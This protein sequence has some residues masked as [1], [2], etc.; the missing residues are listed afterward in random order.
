MYTAY[1]EAQV[2]FDVFF[3]D[4]K[5][6]KESYEKLKKVLN[7]GQYLADILSRQYNFDYSNCEINFYIDD[8]F[9][10]IYEKPSVGVKT[11]IT[12]KIVGNDEFEYNLEDIVFNTMADLK[13]KKNIDDILP[14]DC[15]ANIDFF[16][17]DVYYV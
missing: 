10:D 1:I 4:S 16:D 7:D 13:I 12:N 9:D 5:T 14:N 17:T 15:Y 8:E 2:Y 11:C 3:D 6:I